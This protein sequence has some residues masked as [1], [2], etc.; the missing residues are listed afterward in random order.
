MQKIVGDSLRA[1]G[2]RDPVGVAEAQATLDR[3]Y[4]MLDAHLATRRWAAGSG[5]STRPESSGVASGG[6]R[7]GRFHGFIPHYADNP[8]P[9]RGR[10]FHLWAWSSACSQA[11]DRPLTIT[12]TEMFRVQ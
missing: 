2:D 5:P 8:L 12:A 4:T 7:C 3:A 10:S 6:S 11:F 9:L 1:E